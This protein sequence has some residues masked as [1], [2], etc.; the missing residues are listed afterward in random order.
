MQ[1]Y[2][3]DSII[4]RFD[5]QV[6]IHSG[7]CVRG[8]RTVFDVKRRPWVDIDGATPDAIAE[9]VLRCPSGAL[10]YELRK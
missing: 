9:Q 2:E 8:L 6:C 7:C 3:N 5:P 1:E 10:S 4:V